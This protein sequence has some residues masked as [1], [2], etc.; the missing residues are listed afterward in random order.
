MRVEGLETEGSTRHIRECRLLRE[1]ASKRGARA[2]NL[3]SPPSL[4]RCEGG[5]F[6]DARNGSWRACP[7]VPRHTQRRA[8][9]FVVCQWASA[10]A[11][12]AQS[13]HTALAGPPRSWRAQDDRVL[14]R[15]HPLPVWIR[16]PYPLFAPAHGTRAALLQMAAP[17]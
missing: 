15:C 17:L 4:L 3:L 16:G 8:M 10:G 14:T 7:D 13:S 9:R 5:W 2:G 1:A 6:G 12:R 11:P